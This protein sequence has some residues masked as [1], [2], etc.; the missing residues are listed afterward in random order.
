MEMNLGRL[1]EHDPRSRNFAFPMLAAPVLKSI[2]WEHVAPVLDQGNLGSCT[3]NA[4]AQCLNTAAFKPVRDK[5]HAGKFFAESDAV[6]L[7]SKAT[8][9]D[10]IDGQ[11]PPTDTGSSGLGV[12]KSARFYKFIT[13]YQ[14]TFTFQAFQQALRHG[15][16]LVGTLWYSGMFTP[17]S[18]GLA[19]VKGSVQGGHEYLCLG[20]D[21][22][23]RQLTFLNSWSDQWG[24]KGRFRLGYKDFQR[25]LDEEGD[26]TVPLL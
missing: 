18:T 7:Y 20:D 4:M 8:Q 23:A 24:K 5:F 12:A 25:L 26:V 13:S 22:G 15:P 16:V 19:H 21:V 6:R 1:V 11:Y 2:L 10:A 3:G 17:S 9:L 14:H